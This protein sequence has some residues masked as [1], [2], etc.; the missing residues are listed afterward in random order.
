MFKKLFCAWCAIANST[1]LNIE[2]PDGNSQYYGTILNSSNFGIKGYYPK[3]RYFSFELYSID[4]WEPFWSVYDKQIQ[5]DNNPYKYDIEYADNLSYNLYIDANYSSNFILLYR[6]YMGIDLY[7]GVD[8]PIIEVNSKELVQCN[9]SSRPVIDIQDSEPDYVLYE[10]NKNN[11]FYPPVT[12]KKLFINANARYMIAYY[13]ES[14][15]NYAKITT[16]LPTIPINMSSKIYQTRYFSFS[17]VDLSEPKQTIQT[18]S[19]KELLSESDYLT[20]YVYCINKRDLVIHLTPPANNSKSCL[21]IFGIL[22]R[23]LL[24]QFKYEI[25]NNRLSQNNL[26]KVMDE[27]YPLIEWY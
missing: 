9:Q 24:P 5:T 20:L 26:M 27:Y 1:L 22:Y 12:K 10:Q 6:I 16:K 19:D 21:S 17:T 25:P 14:S 18:I 7:G 13:N 15:F 3:S 11:N 2:W 4:T 23:Q 8:L